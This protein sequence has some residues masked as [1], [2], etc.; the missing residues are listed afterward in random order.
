[1]FLQTPQPTPH[2]PMFNLYHK[3]IYSGGQWGK[4]VCGLG[5]GVFDEG[6]WRGLG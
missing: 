2:F 5:V 3:V 4:G 1:M 6:I